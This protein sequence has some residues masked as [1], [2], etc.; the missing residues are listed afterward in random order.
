MIDQIIVGEKAS[1]DDFGASVAKRSVS[2]P[3]KKEIKESVPFSN[4][5]Y[6]FTKINGEI[7]WEERELKY[8]F[9]MVAQ[10][11]EKLME[12]E[13]AFANWL[14]NVI[15]QELHDPII[16]DYHYIVTYSDMDFGDEDGLE[17]TTATVTFS[18]YPYKIANY[19]KMFEFEVPASESKTVWIPNESSHR[20]SPIIASSRGITLEMGGTE[21]SMG[22]G[23]VTDE[24]FKLEAG[25]NCI[26]I[27]NNASD[28]CIV[29]F[30]FREEVF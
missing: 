15:G 16:P 7:Y 21:Y 25:L 10:T 24:A 2:Q 17:K 4:T 5:T 27:T 23:M 1:F 26:T 20:I 30:R 3:A 13:T 8:T 11:P 29:V 14:M 19:E 18:A 6:D 22:A 28:D 9:E 12:M